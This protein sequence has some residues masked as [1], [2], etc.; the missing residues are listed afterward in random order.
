MRYDSKWQVAGF[1]IEA[2]PL[3]VG[4]RILVTGPTT[5]ALETEVSEIRFDLQP[6]PTAKQGQRVSIPIDRKVRAS[7][8]LFKLVPADEAEG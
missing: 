3:S 1:K 5:G 6:V 2:A 8:K 7:D 4:D